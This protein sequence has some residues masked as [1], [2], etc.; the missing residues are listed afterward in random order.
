MAPNPPTSHPQFTTYFWNSVRI[1]Y[2][3]LYHLHVAR[4]HH[5]NNGPLPST[6]Q[7]KLPGKKMDFLFKLVMNITGK[8]KYTRSNFECAAVI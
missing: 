7:S 8:Q 6:W 5:H 4:F 2:I 3:F 1:C